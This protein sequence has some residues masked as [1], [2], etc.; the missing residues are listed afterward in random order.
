MWLSTVAV[1]CYTIKKAGSLI[2]CCPLHNVYIRQSPY[3]WHRTER[4]SI[5]FWL[6]A[7]MC[8]SPQAVISATNSPGFGKPRQSIACD[9]LSLSMQ[10]IFQRQEQLSPCTAAIWQVNHSWNVSALEE[11]TWHTVMMRKSGLKLRTILQ[12]QSYRQ[13][14][15]LGYKWGKIR[16]HRSML[17]TDGRQ[18]WRKCCRDPRWK[19]L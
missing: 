4:V 16:K 11:S 1:N 19:A 12:L 2:L 6:K 8:V 10:T 14:Y 17:S 13:I 9:L 3:W 5:V 7:R 15:N 18:R